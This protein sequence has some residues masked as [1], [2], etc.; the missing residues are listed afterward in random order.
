VI[1]VLVVDDHHAIRAGLVALLRQEPGFVPVATAT[2]V[3]EAAA[4]GASGTAD[5]AVIDYHLPDG[6]AVDVC[7]ALPPGVG[8]V[9]YTGVPLEAVLI[10]ALMAGALGVVDKAGRAEE[11]FDA[12]RAV[13]RGRAAH[14]PVTRRALAGAVG[15]VSEEDW[16]IVGMALD[17]TP[18]ADMAKALRIPPAELEARVD[19]VL[20]A[21][22]GGHGAPGSTRGLTAELP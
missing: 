1:R 11:L 16:P 12:V 18:F 3:D 21:V 8:A 19:R 10:P 4:L 7:R 5:V 20:R 17:H 13:A 15:R 6:S 2:S 22:A 9:V 14:P